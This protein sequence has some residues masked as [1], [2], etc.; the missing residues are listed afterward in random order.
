MRP[1]LSE[2]IVDGYFCNGGQWVKYG[3]DD[4][5][6]LSQSGIYVGSDMPQLNRARR[7]GAGGAL[8][9]AA[10]LF[11]LLCALPATAQNTLTVLIFGTATVTSSPA[12]IS[13]TVT[14]GTGC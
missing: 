5:C 3:V 11:L 10:L 12:G 2:L 9:Y 8:Q 7:L 14:G 4:I 13:C 6:P 1:K